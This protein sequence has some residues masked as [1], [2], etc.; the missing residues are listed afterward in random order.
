MLAEL[1]LG[2]QDWA[3]VIPA[4]ASALHE[5]SMDSLGRS[6]DGLAGSPI[7]AMTGILPKR[8]LPSRASG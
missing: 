2:P 3:S 7:D 6:P 8:P 5:A 1:K 4:I